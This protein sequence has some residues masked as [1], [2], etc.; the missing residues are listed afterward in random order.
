MKRARIL[1]A[2]DHAEFLA[3]A[4]KLIDAEFEVVGM[5]SGGQAIVDAAANLDPDLVVLDISMPGLNGIEA[6]LQLKAAG[7]KTKVVFLTVHKDQ[8]YLRS[9]L[10]TGALGYVVKDRLASDL[11]PALREALAG[12]RFVSLFEDQNI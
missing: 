12:R 2:D 11:V 3:L 9:A 8:D 5:L 1:L 7:R 10:A 4:V 6:A